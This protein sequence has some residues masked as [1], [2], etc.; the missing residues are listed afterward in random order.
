MGPM[1]RMNPLLNRVAGQNGLGIGPRNALWSSMPNI[2][3]AAQNNQMQQM[4][5]FN[6]NSGSQCGQNFGQMNYPQTG[7]MNAPP[8][9]APQ[10]LQ[11][12]PPS[13]PLTSAA[14]GSIFLEPPSN[15]PNGGHNLAQNGQKLR[16]FARNFGFG[17]AQFGSIKK[18]SK[19]NQPNQNQPVNRRLRPPQLATPQGAPCGSLPDLTTLTIPKSNSRPSS[20]KESNRRIDSPGAMRQRD[21]TGSNSSL[22]SPRNPRRA[23]P[24][25]NNN[26]MS[27]NMPGSSP[28]SP[29]SASFNQRLNNSNSLP[30]SPQTR[31]ET[32]T[33]ETHFNSFAQN[34]QNN[35]A[36]QT[37][38]NPNSPVPNIVF[39]PSNENES[40]PFGL[41][42]VS[43]PL[44][45]HNF[46]A[47]NSSNG[48]NNAASFNS[49]GGGAG[50]LGNQPVGNVINQHDFLNENFLNDLAS[51]QT[52]LDIPLIAPTQQQLDMM[53]NGNGKSQS[54]SSILNDM[55]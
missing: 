28:G 20:A 42:P 39:T 53:Q 7:Q 25:G 23:H 40:L 18:S 27:W 6:Y 54:L 41:E 48:F 43:H 24:Y 35:H 16:T 5:N 51:S 36:Q 46:G 55:N 21:S 4:T 34:N 14:S 3:S 15:W 52:P 12:M 33:F 44:E 2:H 11:S 10:A 37:N 19:N 9:S 32:D 30:S 1:S 26:R 31:S 22:A 8:I 50:Q 47:T 45:M 13:Y 38:H 17:A 29:V 49:S